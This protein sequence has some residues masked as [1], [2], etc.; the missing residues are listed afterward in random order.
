LKNKAFTLIELLAVIVILAII[1]LIAIP[2]ILNIIEDTKISAVKQ[3]AQNYMS[4]LELYLVSSE[5][6]KTKLTFQRGNK[7]NVN[8]MTIIENKTY[9]P[10]NELI[11]ISGSIPT[12]IDDYVIIDDDGKVVSSKLTIDGYI[13]EVENRKIIKISKSTKIDLKEIKLNY[14][15]QVMEIGGTFKI[16]PEFNPIDA[17]NQ[18]VTYESSNT[19]VVTVDD[20]GNVKAVSSGEAK[21]IVTSKDN[22]NIKKECNITVKEIEATELKLN[23]KSSIIR[24][25]GIERLRGTIKP[26]NVTSN[27]LTWTSSNPN[28][29][30]V[31]KNGVV[32][33]I[34]AGEATI[35]ATTVNGISDTSIITVVSNTPQEYIINVDGESE[36]SFYV[37]ST[38]GDNVNL[39]MSRNICI[40]GTLATSTNKCSV[41]WLSKLDYNNDASFGQYGSSNKGPITAMN[42][43]HEATKNWTNIP[44]IQINYSEMADVDGYGKMT[45]KDNITKITMKDG[46]ETA[47]Y[48][49]LKSRLI[50]ESEIINTSCKKGKYGTCPTWMVNGLK[51]NEY[52]PEETKENINIGCYWSLSHSSLNSSC[53]YLVSSGGYYTSLDISQVFCGVR[54][55]ITVPKSDLS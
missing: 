6:D 13:I 46:T 39:I 53:A 24:V 45:T 37:L 35:T 12:G 38:D 55:V 30:M 31:N 28:I 47:R 2:I 48:E 4:S 7:Y 42:Y 19:K 9:L 14:D 33:G 25:G 17:S 34:S 43:L 50:M 26:S 52:Y 18:E 49:N 3:S 5:V 10:L 41:A 27:A 23:L 22:S 32:T 1:A 16:I 54:P 8:N 21:I 40:D 20:Q 44:N 15:E 36:Y 29:A 51:E 11:E